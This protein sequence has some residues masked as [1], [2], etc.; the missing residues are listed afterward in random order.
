MIRPTV[1]AVIPAFNAERWIAGAIESVLGQ[2]FRDLECIV[3]DDGSTDGTSSIVRSYGPPVIL[4]EQ[5]NAGVS[6]ARNAGIIAARGQFIAFLDADDVWR[7]EKIERQVEAFQR[8]PDLGLVYTSLELVDESGCS[9]GLMD[10]ADP[11]D[12][13]ASRLRVQGGDPVPLA[14]GGTVPAA[15]LDRVGLFDERLSTCADNDLVCR[16]ARVYPLARVAEPLTLYRQ[17]DGA[18]HTDLKRF[19]HDMALVLRKHLTGPQRVSITGLSYR[20]S[21][22]TLYMYLA[23]AWAAERR[24]SAALRSGWIALAVHP[25]RALGAFC[26]HLGGW[27]SV[28][29]RQNRLVDPPGLRQ[30]TA[31]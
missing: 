15:V 19:E 1:S 14:Q 30:A 8:D 25:T 6:A 3:V 24:W 17:V 20:R 29:R 18:M 22:A 23:V 7:P 5:P 4:L 26:D 27:I 28:R 13:L 10:A 31:D 9:L 11:V 21:R 2:T 12:A 16:I